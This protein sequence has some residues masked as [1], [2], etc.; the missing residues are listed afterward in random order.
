M[1][2][3]ATEPT[4]L[5]AAAASDPG[6]VREN[7][8]DRFHCDPSRGLFIVVD[9]VGGHAAGEK[10]AE[11]ALAMLRT[12]L[13]RETGSPAD[14]VREAITLANNEVYRLAQTEPAWAG[15]A[16]VLTVAIVRDGCLTV[17]H[18]GDTRLYVFENGGVLKVTHDHSPVGEREDQGELDEAAAMRHPRRNEIYR[19][20]GSGPHDPTDDDFIEIVERPFDADSALLVCSDGLSDLVT[21]SSLAEIVHAHAASPERV[22]ARL[23]AAANDQGGKDNVTAVFAAGPGFAGRTRRVGRYGEGSRPRRRPGAAAWTRVAA[24]LALGCAI[25]LG[26]GYAAWMLWSDD[27][28]ERL[29]QARRP[30]AWARTWTVG[31]EPGAEF[32]SIRDALA[33]ARPGDVVLVGPGE[34]RAPISL[35][36]AVSLVSRRPHEAIIRPAFG[37]E[38]ASAVHVRARTRSRLSGFTVAGD[39]EHPLG[40]GVL[41]DRGAIVEI[42]DVE[43]SGASLAG[44]QIEEGARATLRASYLHDNGGVGVLIRP[45]SFPRL[46]HNVIS[47]NGRRAGWVQPGIL[48]REPTALVCFGN[49]VAG[50]GDD[51]IH[52]LSA[53]RRAEIARDN[54]VGPPAPPTA[55]PPARPPR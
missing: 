19:D 3:T 32:T 27:L 15:M 48:L 22:V 12:R 14:R 24:T 55:K 30:A 2:S 43:V 9:G 53:A 46:L 8:E 37:A 18:V 34:Y 23:V 6:L 47:G 13:E 42:D 21:S 1:T 38:P 44:V 26:L 45:E 16:C 5:A 41:V 54:I 31:F 10:A 49:I 20:V 50:N 11:T 40:T 51:Q 4:P 29:L 28:P 17:G 7:N 39:A 52:G 35:P 33:R 25:G 36:D